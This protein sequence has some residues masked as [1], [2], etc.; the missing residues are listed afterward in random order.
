MKRVEEL[1]EGL[2]PM[3]VVSRLTGLSPDTIRVWQ[4]R[5]G[6]VDPQRTEGNARRFTAAD[7][8]RLVLLRDAVEHGHKISDIA[9]LGEEALRGL[10]EQTEGL[11]DHAAL[12]AGGEPRD[13]FAKVR[14]DYLSAITRFEARRA[15]EIL[16]RAASLLP[17]GDFVQKTVIPIM[18][19]VGE[20]WTHEELGIAH[21]HLVSAH[22]R[23]LLDTL[24]RF[25][26]PQPG[27][28]TVLVTTPPEHLHEFG[29]L[30]G[31]FLAA[32]RGFEPVY[33]GPNLPEEEILTAA[34]LSRA[35]L[36]ILSVA[37][38]TPKK[39]RDLL[40]PT[41]ERVAARIET[42][43]GLPPDHSLVTRL[44]GIRLFHRY[45]DLDVALADRVLKAT[46]P[47]RRSA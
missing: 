38:D 22:V 16:A 4:R 41:L 34:E 9:K 47:A 3:R 45:E 30:A 7:V 42:W 18:H 31:A 6:A 26:T 10:L 20:R 25:V 14:E 39:E 17:P 5:Y 11:D 8:R 1:R 12:A 35:D 40:V 33:L 27:A 43:I 13:D 44:G 19:E 2:Y 29:A 32:S 28:P 36:L 15:S 23:S 24:L 21:E 46:P 37:R